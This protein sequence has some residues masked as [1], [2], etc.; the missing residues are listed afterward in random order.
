MST[1]SAIIC[2][3]PEGYKG[4]YCY[5]DGYL[6]GVGYTL[7]SNFRSQEDAEA[8]VALGDL[9]EVAG[10]VRITPIGNH[11]Y[12]N[13]E[14]GTVVAYHRDRGDRYNKALPYP[15]LQ[16]C[17]LRIGRHGHVYFFDG[18]NWLHNGQAF[19]VKVSKTCHIKWL[20]SSPE[21]V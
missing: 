2:K 18:E 16:A 6:E 21:P 5:W 19:K 11:S 1:R 4:V 10:C 14:E 15:T 9:S 7:Q 13:P 17:S 8:L 20:P 3:T 12:D